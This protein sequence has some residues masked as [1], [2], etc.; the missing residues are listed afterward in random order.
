[1]KTTGI[2]AILILILLLFVQCG[3]EK[4]KLLGTIYFTEE[5]RKIIPYDSSATIVLIDSLGSMLEYSVYKPTSQFTTWHDPSGLPL[6]TQHDI[7]YLD[8]YYTEWLSIK[9]STPDYFSLSI[10]YTNPWISPIEK[11]LFIEIH[12]TNSY[13][14]INY[15][16]GSC[17]FESGT[18]YEDACPLQYYDSLNIIDTVFQSAYTL[19]VSSGVT[20]PE[21]KPDSILLVFYSIQDGIIGMQTAKGHRWRL[22]K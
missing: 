21:N 16:S 5:D 3:K 20:N 15:F 12:T 10:S 14:G 22:K 4:G 19:T 7:E 1:M 9:E 18:L 2:N 8:Y 6:N 13:P 11:K 17:K